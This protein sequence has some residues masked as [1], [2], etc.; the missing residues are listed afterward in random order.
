MAKAPTYGNTRI[1]LAKPA[2][3]PR[4]IP[5]PIIDEEN[6]IP[7]KYQGDIIFNKTIYSRVDFNKKINAE[8]S[9]LNNVQPPINIEEFFNLYNE[10]FFDIPKEGENSHSTI[11]ETSLDYV[12][13]YRN[14][15]QSTVDNL[16]QQI[17][18]LEANIRNLELEIIRLS[19]GDVGSLENEISNQQAQAQYQALL[20]EIGDKDNPNIKYEDIEDKLRALASQGLTENLVD[21]LDTSDGPVKDLEEAYEKAK[22]SNLKYVNTRTTSQ[23]KADIEKNSSNKDKRDLW[24]SC[25]ELAKFQ[26]QRLEDAEAALNG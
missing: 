21:K 18:E 7:D 9:E 20:A 19:T 25:D 3:K 10:I 26:K 13:N 1:D 22:A 2:V 12:E 23:W 16:G 17:I 5:K 6:A 4:V 11:I 15:L 14:P 8:F 24:K